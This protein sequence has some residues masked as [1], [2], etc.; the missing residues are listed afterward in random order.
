MKCFIK[1]VSALLLTIATLA[2]TNGT[3]TYAANTEVQGSGNDSRT[4]VVTA[5]I[6]SVYSVSLPAQISLT[7]DELSN[8]YVGDVLQAKAD[9]YFGIITFGAAGKISNQ[10]KVFI[11]PVFPCLMTGSTS[12][13]T[14]NLK[15]VLPSTRIEPQ[16]IWTK[17]QIGN[18]TYDGVILTSCNY[19]YN[20]GLKVGILLS[21]VTSYENYRGNLLFNFG[22]RIN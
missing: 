7:Y 20:D 3:I 10:E 22:I 6:T 4:V 19:T 16:T 17:A 21:D 5:N 9:G 18:C 11:E 1:T 12:G 2:C 14:I 8:V 15:K 13:N